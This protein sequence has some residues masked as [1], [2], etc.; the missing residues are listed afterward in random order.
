MKFRHI[1]ALIAL[2]VVACSQ[3]VISPTSTPTVNHPTLAP[4][5]LPEFAP[6]GTFQPAAC[7]FILPEDTQEGEDVE[8]GYLFVPERR[9]AQAQPGGRVIRLAVAIFHPPGGPTRPDPLMYLSG[10]PGVSALELIRYQFDLLSEPA[11]STGRDLILFDQR[12]VGLSRPALDCPGFDQLALEL[13][14]REVDGRQV[15]DEEIET[16]LLNSLISCRDELEKIADLSEYNT[17]AS[18]ADVNDLQAALGY[19]EINLWGGSYGTRL[20][21]EVMRRYPQGLRSVVLD[22]VYP[23]DVDLYAQAPDNFSRALERM[24]ESCDNNPVC[25]AAFP[26]V[27]QVLFETVAQLNTKPAM[28]EITNPFTGEKYQS[29]MDGNTILALTF[30]LL[31]DSQL[32]Y[33]IPQYIYDASQGNF[34]AF[35]Q[36]RGALIG[37]RSRTSRGMM[38]SVQCQEELAFSSLQDFQSRL[39]RHPELEDTYH[40]SLMGEIVYSI[41]QEWN[42]GA[43]D[44]SSKQPVS[45]AVPTLLMSGEFDPVTPPAWGQQAAKTLT[46][47]YSYEYPGIGHGASVMAGCPQEMMVAFLANPSVAPNSACIEAMRKP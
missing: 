31:Y 14:D 11:F 22:A 45:S 3:G 20:A 39:A 12:G 33:L 10:G 26:D 34:T 1:S 18:A 41:C 6:P 17:A 38:L 9:D 7:R 35:D 24:F 21:L 5:F 40:N 19:P 16:H 43:A 4:A 42:V 27:R 47:A 8:C 23:P 44:A 37:L 15:S 2:F 29:W 30:Q 13:V 25:S 28:S 32:R 46:Q 36:V